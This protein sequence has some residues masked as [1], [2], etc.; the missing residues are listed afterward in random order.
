L[1]IFC[2]VLSIGLLGLVV[3]NALRTNERQHQ[4]A[5]I[6]VRL[7][8]LKARMDGWQIRSQRE[9]LKFRTVANRA[10]INELLAK[11]T[12]PTV[13][14]EATT[15]T[16]DPARLETIQACREFARKEQEDI[17]SELA[18]ARAE[19]E[20]IQQDNAVLQKEVD[21]IRTQVDA[22]QTEVKTIGK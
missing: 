4:V 11:Q 8:S 20:A 7:D 10:R 19:S 12:N 5:L 2:L 18:A 21:A 22:L 17:Q 14:C 6:Q 3:I 13:K 15:A 1:P 9:S 16:D